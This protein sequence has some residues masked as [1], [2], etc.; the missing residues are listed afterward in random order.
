[1]HSPIIQSDARHDTPDRYCYCCG[2]CQYSAGR[3]EETGQSVRTAWNGMGPKVR[4]WLSKLVWVI[5]GKWSIILLLYVSGWPAFP[6]FMTDASLVFVSWY[7][8]GHSVLHLLHPPPISLRKEIVI[9]VIIWWSVY[10]YLMEPKIESSIW[11]C[12]GPSVSIKLN[13]PSRPWKL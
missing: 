8:F 4:M 3:P 9:A 7:R 5:N 2:Q 6:L 10:S 13:T 12:I 11:T 1:M